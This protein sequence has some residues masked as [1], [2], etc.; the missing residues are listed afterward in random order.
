MNLR[1][2]ILILVACAAGY[3][4]GALSSQSPGAAAANNVVRGSRFELVNGA[5]TVVATWEV[6]SNGGVH[7]NLLHDQ[8]TRIALG[9]MP[10][11]RPFFRMN[12]Q[13]EK[14]RMSLSLN[15]GDKPFFVMSDE[16]WEGRVHLGFMPPDTFPYSNWDHWGLLF[17]AFGSEHAVAGMGMTN[18]RSNPAEPFLRIGGRS[19]R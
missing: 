7:L 15:Q 1:D 14:N 19:I 3:L 16:R 2:C 11:G 9:T 10:D 13:D 4:G 12:G 8:H 18:T 5:G 17:R 6:E